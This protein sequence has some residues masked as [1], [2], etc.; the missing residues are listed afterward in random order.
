MTADA[1]TG[2]LNGRSLSG[3]PAE[4]FLLQVQELRTH[5]HTPEGVVKAVDGVS[6]EVGRGEIIGL[7]GESGC[8]KSVTALSILGLVPEPQ[9]RLAGGRIWFDQVDLTT[10][11]RRQMRAIRGN[12]IAMVFQEPMTSLNPVF[13]LGEQIAEI[14]M[15]HYGLSRGEGL[16]KA[17][18][19]LERLG[20]PSPDRRIHEYPHHISGGMRQRVMIAMALAC[21]P[22][23]I[24][25]D[26][27]TTALD[28]TVQA[29]IIAEM[30]EL[31]Q[32]SKTSIIL[33]TH[34]L[35]IVAETAERV[36]VMYAG[37]L[38]EE[39]DVVPLF[40]E[41]LHPYT[42]GLLASIPRPGL[43]TGDGRQRLPEIPG[44]VPP[45]NDLPDGCS[46]HPRCPRVRPVCRESEPALVQIGPNRKAACWAVS[47]GW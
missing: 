13:T 1:G 36:I 44:M 32:S 8:G 2:E 5:F 18:R 16:R 46:F 39:S 47:E 7:V 37:K 6:F 23:L 38:V 29:Q 22:E 34:N 11:D 43:K 4:E 26:E 45:L 15:E 3:S 14:Y 28:V 24:I 30:R 25:A 40:R 41:P 33:I 31:Q 42:S 17:K 20:I 10:L 27:P 9:G 19:M 12:R 35:G 21:D